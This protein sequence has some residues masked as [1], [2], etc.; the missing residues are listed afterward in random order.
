MEI[1]AADNGFVPMMYEGK[2][3]T[4]IFDR[5]LEESKTQGPE[6]GI[7]GH[8]PSLRDSIEKEGIHTPVKVMT[9]GE[10]VDGVLMNG[11]HRA[12]SAYD[13]DPDYPVPVEYREH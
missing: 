1:A 12:V 6:G 4:Y 10:R 8:G 11:H 5:K 7:K 2:P 9:N 13:I 3:T